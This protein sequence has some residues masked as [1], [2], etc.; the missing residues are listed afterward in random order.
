MDK[1][2]EVMDCPKQPV[3]ER[4]DKKQLREDDFYKLI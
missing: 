1:V 2:R 3:N 4:S